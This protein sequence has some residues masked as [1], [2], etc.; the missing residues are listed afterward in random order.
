MELHGMEETQKE[1]EIK[2]D[3]ISVSEMKGII[4]LQP[5][6]KTEQKHTFQPVA[7]AIYLPGCSEN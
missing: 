4:T 7:K 1:G 2:T 6:E 5:I 3:Y